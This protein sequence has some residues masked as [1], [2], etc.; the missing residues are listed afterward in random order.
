MRIVTL[1]G[2]ADCHLCD[3]AREA[4][5]RIRQDVPFDLEERDIEADDALHRSYFERIPVVT[6][7]GQEMFEYFVDESALRRALAMP[8]PPGDELESVR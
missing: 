7:D 1:Y 6:V 5:Q 4:L 2:K 8:R 3:E